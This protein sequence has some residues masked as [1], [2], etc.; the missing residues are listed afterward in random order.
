MYCY[1]FQEI[2]SLKHFKSIVFILLC[3]FAVVYTFCLR[4]AISDQDLSYF[5]SIVATFVSTLLSIIVGIFLFEYQQTENTKLELKR[6][7]DIVKAESRDIVSILDSGEEMSINLQSGKS[8]KVMITFISP[9]AHEEAGKSGGF[10]ALI[11]ENLFHISRKI[12]MY[13][14]KTEHLLGLLRISANEELLT[15][16]INNVNETKVAVIQ[17]CKQV[18]SQVSKA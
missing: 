16:A 1:A 7:Q 14:M 8:M 10:D 5:D 12:R 2:S 11:T 6:L 3:I 18:E 9:L 13:N 17:D 4:E 15:H